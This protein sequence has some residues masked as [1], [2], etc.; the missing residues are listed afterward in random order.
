[1]PIKELDVTFVFK[2]ARISLM[3]WEGEAFYK[4]KKAKQSQTFKEW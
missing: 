4:R 2:K 3:Y 1:M